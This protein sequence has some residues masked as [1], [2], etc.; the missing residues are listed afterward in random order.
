[1]VADRGGLVHIAT[2]PRTV[3]SALQIPTKARNFPFTTTS[4]PAAKPTQFDAP[5]A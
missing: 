4:K 3:R 1:M 5:W 2:R